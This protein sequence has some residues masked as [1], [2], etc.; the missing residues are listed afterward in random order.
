MKKFLLLAC[1]WSSLSIV[2]NSQE[3][4]T[5]FGG[6]GIAPHQIMSSDQ[7]LLIQQIDFGNSDHVMDG[8]G[9]DDAWIQMGRLMRQATLGVNQEQMDKAVTMSPE[10]WIDWQMSLLDFDFVAF[11]F[12]KMERN[13]KYAYLINPENWFPAW[14][15]G[16]NGDEFLLAWWDY[17]YHSDDLLRN[18]IAQVYSQ[19][20]VVSRGNDDLVG[21]DG[22]A[23]YYDMLRKNAFGNFKDLLLDV[24]LHPAMGV[25]LNHLNNPKAIPALN[26]YPDENYAREV[27]QLFSIGLLQLNPDGSYQLDE[28]G[29]TIPTYNQS[30]IKNL[31][32]V[33]TGL[34]GGGICFDDDLRCDGE[35]EFD[36]W[37][38]MDRWSLNYSVPMKMYMEF[39]DRSQKTIFDGHVI[40]AYQTGIKDVE[41]AVN[42]LFNHPNVG[43][44]IGKQLI[45]KLVTSN[46][47]PA[48]VEDIT[49]IFND[50]GQGV[51]GDMGAVI[52]G[53]LL[54]PEARSCHSLT[55][56]KQ[57]KLQEPMIRYLELIKLLDI[58]PT[59]D[60]ELLFAHFFL[61]QVNQNLFSSPTVFNF[62]RPDYQ[63]SG[64][65]AEN[66]LVAGEFQLHNSLTS[67]QYLARLDDILLQKRVLQPHWMYNFNWGIY[68]TDDRSVLKKY[69]SDPE[70][71][72]NY[73]NRYFFKGGMG[74][75]TRAIFKNM[76]WE[77]G[78]LFSTSLERRVNAG[79]MLTSMS[80]DFTILK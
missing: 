57:G 27:M 78:D 2:G 65:I 26:I 48:Y 77:I 38:G 33:F 21:G 58:I 5:V 72:I 63:P 19:I 24:T 39:H 60:G 66:G 46:P 14:D 7:A 74:L 40:P 35:Y 59:K 69:A 80:P 52:K 36:P 18:K 8:A 12:D 70:A 20:F 71:Y 31:A 34:S 47:S 42:Y 44:F 62:Y 23:A 67:L 6:K 75:E 73:L 41:M 54:H 37:F 43:P 17:I 16:F 11:A 79:L 56:S 25:Y 49:R 1:V 22:L 45:Q 28:E 68:H 13:R 15:L 64:M 51:R 32:K 61:E 55:D 76:L 53:I 29:N 10:E 3:E 4:I 30:V 50:N 9:L